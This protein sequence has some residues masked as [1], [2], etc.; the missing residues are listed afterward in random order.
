VPGVRSRAMRSTLLAISLVVLTACGGEEVCGCSLDT[1]APALATTYSADDVEAVQQC[2]D[3]LGPTLG[4]AVEVDSQ[5]GH[6]DTLDIAITACEQ[7]QDQ[8]ADNDSQ[9]REPLDDIVRYIS[10]AAASVMVGGFMGGEQAE[11]QAKCAEF[12]QLAAD[13]IE[14]IDAR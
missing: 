8:L 5:N 6:T 10:L 3:A 4:A 11:L 9:L 12:R 1:T 7:A 13:A 14:G 2:V